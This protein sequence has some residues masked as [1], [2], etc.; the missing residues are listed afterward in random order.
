MKQ[1]QTQFNYLLRGSFPFNQ[2]CKTKK[3][4]KVRPLYQPCGCVAPHVC[5]VMFVC[6]RE[7]SHWLISFCLQ[8]MQWCRCWVLQQNNTSISVLLR[9][10]QNQ[11]QV[12][13]PWEHQAE[14]PRGP[15][16]SVNPHKILLP[17]PIKAMDQ[18]LLLSVMLQILLVGGLC[19]QSG[20]GSGVPHLMCD[21]ERGAII[22]NGMIS[23]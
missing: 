6:E 21:L 2:V 14:G 11:S 5:G 10:R 13:E 20:A 23:K 15:S 17:S 4:A 7:R 9:Y 19:Y 18:L 8:V 12:E 22:T 1:M 3:P 16:Q